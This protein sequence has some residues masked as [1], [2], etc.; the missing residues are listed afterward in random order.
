LAGIVVDDLPAA[1]AWYARVLGRPADAAPMEG[2]LEWHLTGGG[3]LQVVDIQK[4]REVQR[5]AEWGAAGSSSVAFVVESLDDQLA[6]LKSNGI[7]IGQTYTTG[8]SFKT[9]TLADPSG[10]FVT[11]VE[12][13]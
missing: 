8:P 7:A 4:V 3:W 6:L 5:S 2:L 10:N 1:A 13:L 11:F 9:A 12:Q